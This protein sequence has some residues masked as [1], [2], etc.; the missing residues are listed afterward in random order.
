MKEKSSWRRTGS[1]ARCRK[2]KRAWV[3]DCKGAITEKREETTNI[4]KTA[5]KTSGMDACVHGIFPVM[6][7]E[8]VVGDLGGLAVRNTDHHVCC[9]SDGRYSVKVEEN[10]HHRQDGR[11]MSQMIRNQPMVEINAK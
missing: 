9:N 11:Q 7:E 1:E 4:R 8:T 2:R 10:K 6:D 3:D 5:A